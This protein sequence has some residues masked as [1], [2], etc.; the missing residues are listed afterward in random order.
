MRGE[1]IIGSP[2]VVAKDGIEVN[3]QNSVSES[4]DYR[5]DGVVKAECMNN[6]A[7]AANRNNSSVPTNSAKIKPLKWLPRPGIQARYI[8]GRPDPIMMDGTVASL[9]GVV[10]SSRNRSKSP[11]E[12]WESDALRKFA[13]DKPQLIRE[14][15]VSLSSLATTLVDRE[16][17]EE[18]KDVSTV[19]STIDEEAES[20]ETE[21]DRYGWEGEHMSMSSASVRGASMESERTVR[22][23]VN[24][25]FPEAWSPKDQGGKKRGL[26]WRVLSMN[27]R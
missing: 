13:A 9:N 22:G 20:W 15:G 7:C 12:G 2:L 5:V 17:R 26:L 14:A 10:A 27:A 23:S 18:D 3:K 25:G 21:T 6:K 4:E 8:Y 16:R 1:P 24:S 19:S 11:S